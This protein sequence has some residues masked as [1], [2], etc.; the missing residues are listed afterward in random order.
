MRPQIP[1]SQKRLEDNKGTGRHQHH[2]SCGGSYRADQDKSSKLPEI[3]PWNP[4]LRRSPALS[5]K[6]LYQ[7]H[8]KSPVTHRTVITL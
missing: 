7:Y 2:T 3:H 1:G 5:N 4:L 6:G 8:K